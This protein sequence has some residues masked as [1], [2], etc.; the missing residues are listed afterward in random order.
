MPENPGWRK[1][2]WSRYESR[3]LGGTSWTELVQEAPGIHSV[4]PPGPRP[5]VDATVRPV[6]VIEPTLWERMRAL[7]VAG[8]VAIWCTLGFILLLIAA[9][10]VT[11]LSNNG[12]QKATIVPL[13]QFSTTTTI[14]DS[15]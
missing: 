9:G 13:P 5:M 2:P 11:L 15:T 7:P 3:W 12:D 8:Q 14:G 1:D 10:L 4:D 6:P